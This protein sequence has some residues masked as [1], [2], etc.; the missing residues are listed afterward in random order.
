MP[1]SAIQTSRWPLV[2][3]CA[4][5]FLAVPS[6]QRGSVGPLLKSAPLYIL[7]CALRCCQVLPGC[8]AALCVFGIYLSGWTKTKIHVCGEVFIF[9][10]LKEGGLFRSGPAAGYA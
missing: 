6:V 4:R 8:R 7:C 5:I 1:H 10:F 9:R 3:I 2:G